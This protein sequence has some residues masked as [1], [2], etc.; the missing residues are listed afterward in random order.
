MSKLNPEN[1]DFHSCAT[2][3]QM[4]G[5]THP[6]LEIRELKSFRKTRIFFSRRKDLTVSKILP[7][8]DKESSRTSKIQKLDL[9]QD[10]V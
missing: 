1:Q 9:I 3:R 8:G 7:E 2:K 5:P 4:D 6:P 10:F